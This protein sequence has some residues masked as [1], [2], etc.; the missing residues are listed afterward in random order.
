MADLQ[1]EIG[2]VLFD[3]DTPKITE[4]NKIKSLLA[5][6]KDNELIGSVEFNLLVIEAGKNV[7][8]SVKITNNILPELGSANKTAKVLGGANGKTLTYGSTSLPILANN[9]AIVFWDG[10]LKTWSIQQQEPMPLPE[11]SKKIIKDGT[12]PASTGGVFSEIEYLKL[13]IVELSPSITPSSYLN[14]DGVKVTG[15]STQFVTTEP[16]PA[17]KGDVIVFG[18][19]T[20]AGSNTARALWGFNAEGNPVKMYLGTVNAIASKIE[21]PIVEEDVTFVVGCTLGTEDYFFGKKQKLIEKNSV[22]GFELIDS[23]IENLKS[24]LHDK[25]K[26]IFSLLKAYVNANGDSIG[27]ETWNSSDF[28]TAQHNVDYFWGGRTNAGSSTAYAITGYNVDKEKVATILWTYDTSVSGLYKFSITNLDIKYFKICSYKD[29]ELILY[30]QSSK[31]ISMSKVENLSGIAEDVELLKANSTGD[32]KI[33]ANVTWASIGDSIT[34]YDSQIGKKGYQSWIMEAIRF[35]SHSNF[36]FSGQSLTSAPD[37]TSIVDSTVNIGSYGLYTILVGTNDFK[38]NRPIGTVDDYLNNTGANTFYG[39]Y[40]MLLDRIFGKN[41]S[42]DV[43][44]MTPLRRDTEGYA[45]FDVNTAGHTLNDYC[46]AIRWIATREALKLCDLYHYSGMTER[47]IFL[48]APDGLHPH[49]EGNKVIAKPMII[50][51][52]EIYR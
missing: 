42:A 5:T 8:E 18:G 38:L 47:N 12:L 45:T 29:V 52:S 20:Q 46:E 4:V 14:N 24:F 23:E 37:R 41:Q 2:F 11:A 31:M 16:M 3:K 32:G 50:G 21:V 13:G 39:A 30:I 19:T 25:E 51:L 43:M 28:I 35:I 7:N 15:V 10:T 6:N 40:R 33:N 44:L 27:I 17:K 26:V 22:K 1:N 34:W 49:D 36:G 48:I 9:E